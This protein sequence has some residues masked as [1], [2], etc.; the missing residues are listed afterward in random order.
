MVGSSRTFGLPF[1][2]IFAFLALFTF[3]PF[4]SKSHGDSSGELM[5]SVACVH[6][7]SLFSDL[8]RHR[9]TVRHDEFS[10]ANELNDHFKSFGSYK[11]DKVSLDRLVRTF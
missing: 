1:I 11:I 2:L 4:V 9:V 8:S 6:L 7:L 5:R 10:L 3:L